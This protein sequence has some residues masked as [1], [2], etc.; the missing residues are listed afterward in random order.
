MGAYA[1]VAAALILVFS[2][3]SGD[4]V[5]TL[6][7]TS[8]LFLVF[9]CLMDLLYQFLDGCAYYALL[10]PVNRQVTL[11]NCLPLSWIGVFGRVA[12]ASAGSFP[13][14]VSYLIKY[15]FEWAT[16]LGYMAIH[17]IFQKTSVLV[18][19]ALTLLFC[20]VFRQNYVGSNIEGIVFAA[21]F[22]LTFVIITALILLL[23]GRA[24][25]RHIVNFLIGLLPNRGILR[26][27]KVLW[28]ARLTDL[29]RASDRVFRNPKACLLALL[30][31]LLKFAVMYMI[32]WVCFRS[33]GIFRMGLA[34][35]VCLTSFMQ[36]LT[37]VLPSISGLGSTEVAF[38]YI[39]SPLL[40]NGPASAA[41]LLFRIATYFFPFLVSI[42]VF[43]KN[44]PK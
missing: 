36:L 24:G 11:M 28:K 43:L 27:Q 32:P 17:Y 3:N 9:I 37:G 33:M 5:E 14:E 35:T 19:A 25:F 22:G 18:F 20:M 16:C 38:L 8:P 1:L 7:T 29:Y 6:S 13:L 42:G 12:T 39:Y 40:G 2:Q 26:E 31:H 23:T 30:F 21:G 4:I 10:K 34:R 15:G 41:M 44:R